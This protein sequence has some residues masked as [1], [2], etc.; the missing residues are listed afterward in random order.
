MTILWNNFQFCF[1]PS[2]R[3]LKKKIKT[4][5]F[6]KQLHIYRQIEKMVEKGSY[7]SPYF[8]IY[9][10]LPSV[11]SVTISEPILTYYY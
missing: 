4:L 5:F 2:P 9:L 6:K 3:V 7:V 11:W 1:F 10:H 8:P